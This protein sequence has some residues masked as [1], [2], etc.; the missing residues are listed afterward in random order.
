MTRIGVVLLLAGALTAVAAPSLAQNAALDVSLPEAPLAEEAE[1]AVDAMLSLNPYA[2]LDLEDL[3]ATRS[4]PLFSPSRAPPVEVAVEEVI[5]EEEPEAI[6]E[7]PEIIPPMLQ[8]V[9]VIMTQAKQVAILVDESTG[10]IHRVGAGEDYE[11]W[12]LSIV[13]PRT[14]AFA[15][16][17]ESHSLTLFTEFGRGSMAA[18]EAE[19]DEGFDDEENWS[20]DEN[21]MEDENWSEDEGWLEEEPPEEGGRPPGYASGFLR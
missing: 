19:Y 7:E 5:F 17:E 14:V 11:G 20:D 10:E 9:G 3:E 4:L 6:E 8:L 21:W 13:D 12:T 1:S 16:G 15:M 2:S 18:H